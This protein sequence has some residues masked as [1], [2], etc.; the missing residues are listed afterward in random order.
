MHEI[1]ITVHR[2][3]K[4]RSCVVMR[5]F[6]FVCFVVILIGWTSGPNEVPFEVQMKNLQETAAATPDPYFGL[7]CQRALETAENIQTNPDSYLASPEYAAL[8]ERL[9]E[10]EDKNLELQ[11]QA[12]VFP[13]RA[14]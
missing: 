4:V 10:L 5:R 3:L 8:C 11:K 2:D 14:E 9:Q 13:P 7:K 6:L 12:G 1:E